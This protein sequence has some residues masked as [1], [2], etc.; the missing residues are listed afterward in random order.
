M[1]LGKP[2]FSYWIIAVVALAWNLMGCLNFVMQQNADVV[3]QMP[4]LYQLVINARPAWATAAF[5]LAVFTGAV[6][7]ILLL[8]RRRIAMQLFVLSLIGIVGTIVYTMMAVGIVP[9]V[10]LTL[11]VGIALIWYTSIVQRK[12]WLR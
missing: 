1:D 7:C 9:S 6:G 8:L 11:L 5:G 3:A 12:G 4:E 10:V 2:H